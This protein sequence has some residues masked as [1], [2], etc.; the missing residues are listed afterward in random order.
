MISTTT[1]LGCWND[2]DNSTAGR[3]LLL[4]RKSR[5]EYTILIKF[6]IAIVMLARTMSHWYRFH[7]VQ[8]SR[9]WNSDIDHSMSDGSFYI[10]K[11]GHA[12]FISLRYSGRC[13]IDIDLMQLCDLA[14]IS[15]QVLSIRIYNGISQLDVTMQNTYI[16]LFWR[17]PRISYFHGRVQPII[18][19]SQML[20]ILSIRLIEREIN[21]HI[22]CSQWQLDAKLYNSR[23]KNSLNLGILHN[24]IWL[25]YRFTAQN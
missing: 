25:K 10:T 20:W 18:I 1:E 21:M 14:E 7:A 9:R 4:N 2:V 6:D 16:F 12:I 23:E 22:Y 24:K 8:P 17:M 13:R 11:P 3:Y 15:W 19:F 5:R